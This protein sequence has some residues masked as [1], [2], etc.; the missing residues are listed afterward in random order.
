ME[1]VVACCD[2]DGTCCAP[3]SP[4]ELSGSGRLVSGP[5]RTVD[6]RCK[7]GSWSCAASHFGNGTCL[8]CRPQD[9]GP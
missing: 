4:D 3:S 2:Q 1:A 9:G 7:G 8:P 5:A 6:C